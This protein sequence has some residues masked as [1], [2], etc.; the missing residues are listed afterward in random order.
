M[1]LHFVDLLNGNDSNDGL[2]F[3][4]RKKTLAGVTGLVPGDVVRIAKS[5]D[6]Q[7]LGACT[8][9]NTKTVTLPVASTA[10]VNTCDVAWTS[11]G[12]GGTTTSTISTANYVVYGA[13]ASTFTWTSSFTGK[14]GYA[15]CA[16]ID[17]SAYTQISFY[18]KIASTT[19]NVG[20]SNLVLDLCSD[21]SGN[22]PIVSL[23]LPVVQYTSGTIPTTPFT[24]NHGAALPSNVN[25]IALRFSSASPTSGSIVIDHIIACKADSDNTALNLNTLIS[26]NSVNEPNWL[27]VRSIDN[28]TVTLN[29]GD[30]WIGATGAI[31]TYKRHPLLRSQI[32]TFT[33]SNG[34]AN[35]V[36]APEWICTSGNSTGLITYSFGWNTTDMSTQDGYTAIDAMQFNGP[37]VPAADYITTDKLIGV[38]FSS[39]IITTY[40]SNKLEIGTLHSVSHYNG[41]LSLGSNNC[42]LTADKIYFTESFVNANPSSNGI[43]K[44]NEFHTTSCHTNGT[45]TSSNFFCRGQFVQ[46]DKVVVRSAAVSLNSVPEFYCKD[47]SV[48][49]GG[50]TAT[51]ASGA[52]VTATTSGLCHIDNLTVANAN[53]FVS[54]SADV[55]LSITNCTGTPITAP[56]RNS[57]TVA[58]F[59]DVFIKNYN[60]TGLGKGFNQILQYNTVNSPITGVSTQSWEFKNTANWGYPLTNETEYYRLPNKKLGEIPVKAGIS[61]TISVSAYRLFNTT[62][63]CIFSSHDFSVKASTVGAANNWETLTLSFTPTVDEIVDLYFACQYDAV[64]AG[65]LFYICNLSLT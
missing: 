17:L 39:P 63:C 6:A 16:T 5:P 49:L 61:V 60:G 8:W 38:R 57:G 26:Q 28:T 18:L 27:S 23:P 14:I 20:L 64:N 4:T 56:I 31:T 46:I 1:S 30:N 47:M 62:E 15:P 43:V 3:A 22:T 12:L 37:I 40:T 35:S 25:S 29:L 59:N 32:F 42:Y 41:T 58:G 48:D 44:I 13:S 54:V 36:A 65:Q 55:K 50:V 33:T 34:G 45:I 7:S 24:L 9:A 51:Y 52:A 19:S 21:S 11:G 10:H 2:S 53:Y